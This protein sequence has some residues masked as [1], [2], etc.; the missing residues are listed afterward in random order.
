MKL[1][2]L[3]IQTLHVDFLM[4]TKERH[5]MNVFW[6]CL[7]ILIMTVGVQKGWTLIIYP[8]TGD[9]VVKIVPALALEMV[10]VIILQPLLP[11]LQVS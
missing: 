2:V 6:V 9:V 1:K 8:T 10:I 4:N 7:D 3:S 11:N 5:I